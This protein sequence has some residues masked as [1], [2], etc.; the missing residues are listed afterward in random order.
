[1]TFS[2]LSFYSLDGTFSIFIS[3]YSVTWHFQPKGWLFLCYSTH[4][5][6]LRFVG[7]NIL[8]G[9]KEEIIIFHSNTFYDRESHFKILKSSFH[10]SP[11]PWVLSVATAVEKPALKRISVPS[12]E[13]QFRQNSIFQFTLNFAQS[14]LHFVFVIWVC[15]RDSTFLHPIFNFDLR[16]IRVSAFDIQ[17]FI[18]N[19]QVFE[20]DLQVKW[21]VRS[22]FR[23]Q[24]LA[25][26]LRHPTLDIVLASFDFHPLVSD[27]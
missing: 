15:I 17:L 27:R 5:L 19:S 2:S 3:F 1:M 25:F 21:N 9:N 16:N 26:V 24:H 18:S 23:I 8:L 14:I 22:F 11:V 6:D 13:F 7:K 20:F 10:L 12:M 4:T